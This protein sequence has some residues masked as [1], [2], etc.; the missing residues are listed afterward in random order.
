MQS[1][2]NRDWLICYTVSQT[3][4]WLYVVWCHLNTTLH[5]TAT[6]VTTATINNKTVYTLFL[7]KSKHASTENKLPVISAGH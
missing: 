7:L 5:T 2:Q 1:L 6:S 3:C 4:R